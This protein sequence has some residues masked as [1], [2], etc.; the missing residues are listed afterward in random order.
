MSRAPYPIDWPAGWARTSYR[1]SSDFDK[2]R[3]FNAARDG[4]LREL[5]LM[6][7]RHVVIT[8]NLPTNSKGLPHSASSG[9][10]SDPGI[11]VWWVDRKGNER[12]MACDRYCTAVENMHAIE[13]SLAAIRGLERWGATEIVE[14]AFAGFAALPPGSTN[15]TYTASATPKKKTWR[16]VFGISAAITNSMGLE[17]TDVLAVVKTRHRD[18]I[19]D[20][21]PDAGGNHELAAELNAALAEAEKELGP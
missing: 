4:T 6:H 7:V 5:R 16:E 12:V 15:G 19:K 1:R 14:R 20:A 2:K 11:S 17:P 3:G 9:Q 8:S 13:L 18:A 21:H 10:L